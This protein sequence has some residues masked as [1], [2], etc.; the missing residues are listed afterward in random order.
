MF[1]LLSNYY[2]NILKNKL[3]AEEILY[4]ALNMSTTCKIYI[5]QG[6]IFVL[7]CVIFSYVTLG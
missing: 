4:L 1:V 6:I 2:G 5:L 3:S 7:G